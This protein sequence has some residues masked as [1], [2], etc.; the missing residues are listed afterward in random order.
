MRRLACHGVAVFPP[1]RC[2]STP[3]RL[4]FF[5]VMSLVIGGAAFGGSIATA[6]AS[7]S[8]PD[9]SCF[10]TQATDANA[11]VDC[12][13]LGIGAQGVNAYGSARAGFLDLYVSALA[14][15]GAAGGPQIARV[16]VGASY[17]EW[18][19]IDGGSGTG[20]LSVTYDETFSDLLASISQGDGPISDC[21]PVGTRR[22]E[23]L[24]SA[25]TYGVPFEMSASFSLSLFTFSGD[26]GTREE[27][28]LQVT[29]MVD[30]NSNPVILQMIS[31]PTPDPVTLPEPDTMGSVVIGIFAIVALRVGISYFA[32]RS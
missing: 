2:G 18:V 32:L 20:L 11:S 10:Q 13:I 6:T 22:G 24:T 12:E 5:A 3:R 8:G 15:G 14:A 9:Q 28:D 25:F 21:T 23:C 29:S 19:E 31:D 30:Q 4:V 27:G 26:N 16:T 1:Q 17:D 7:A